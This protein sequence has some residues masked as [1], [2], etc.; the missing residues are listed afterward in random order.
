MQR[1]SLDRGRFAGHPRRGF[2][3]P[4]GGSPSPSKSPPEG[5]DPTPQ[6]A[7]A[8]RPPVRPFGR[9]FDPPGAPLRG[10][11]GF[12]GSPSCPCSAM[13]GV[14]KRSAQGRNAPERGWKKSKWWRRLRPPGRQQWKCGEGRAA[15]GQGWGQ[16]VGSPQAVHGVS[17]PLS[18]GREAP[19]GRAA[20]STS[21][22]PGGPFRPPLGAC[23]CPAGLTTS[24]PG[25]GLLPGNVMRGHP[26]TPVKASHTTQL[27][28]QPRNPRR[29]PVLSWRHRKNKV[30][31]VDSRKPAFHAGFIV[32]TP[33][34]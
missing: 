1:F 27:A 17:L 4:S 30:A 22:L 24:V 10:S 2:P 31:T 14:G 12:A 6:G 34:K 15:G 33:K 28:L 18:T 19:A 3:H 20:I 11:P 16:P 29:Q 8:C 25:L 9:P 13:K 23:F 5:G 32:A 26:R 7:G 21:P